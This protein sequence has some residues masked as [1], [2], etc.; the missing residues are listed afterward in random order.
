MNS[1]NDLIFLLALSAGLVKNELP[2]ILRVPFGL[3]RD[4]SNMFS[5]LGIPEKMN[6]T[7]LFNLNQ[8]I[9]NATLLISLGI[10]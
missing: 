3:S 4:T 9:K 8:T 7:F 10:L 5:V 2:Q 6:K 1:M